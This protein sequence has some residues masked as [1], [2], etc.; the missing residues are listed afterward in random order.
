MLLYPRYGPGEGIGVG[1]GKDEGIVSKDGEKDGQGCG[2]AGRHEKAEGAIMAGTR[3]RKQIIVK[4]V[5]F[6]LF[7]THHP[8]FTMGFFYRPP[9]VSSL[10]ELRETSCRLANY[11][12]I[13][14]D[15]EY[16]DHLSNPTIPQSKKVSGLGLASYDAKQWEDQITAE[17]LITHAKST[18]TTKPEMVQFLKAYLEKKSIRF[19]EGLKGH[20]RGSYAFEAAGIL[21]DGIQLH[22]A[23]NDAW[24]EVHTFVR[25]TA[26]KDRDFRYWN[27]GRQLEGMSWFRLD[28]S[29][30]PYNKSLGEQFLAVYKQN[31]PN[32][33]GGPGNRGGRGGRGGRGNQIGRGNRPRYGGKQCID[34][35]SY[36]R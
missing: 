28:K 14:I 12:V 24:A 34:G 6:F 17:H 35:R 10:E 33:R 27:S 22:N 16:V 8:H 26:M 5:L 1:Q 25:L 3:V 4:M 13:G 20:V 2:D 19:G 15:L 30:L 23:A 31:D 21:D 9:T 29:I 32:R 11:V 36:D 18:I 7:V